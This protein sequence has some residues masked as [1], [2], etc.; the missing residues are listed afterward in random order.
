VRNIEKICLTIGMVGVCASVAGF[1]GLFY[2]PLSLILLWPLWRLAEILKHI[3][4]LIQKAKTKERILWMMLAIWWILHAVHVFVPETGFDAVW[5]H[6]P[7]AKLTVENHR[8]IADPTFYQTFNPLFADSIFFLGYMAGGDLGAKGVAYGFGLLLI[9]VTY[10][11]A[12]SYLP[13][14]E[15]LGVCVLVSGFQVVSW[16]ASSFYID[17]AKAVFELAALAF[18]L[19]KKYLFA[20]L[21]LGASLASKLFS[22]VLIPVY[23]WIAKRWSMMWSIVLLLPFLGMAYSATGNPV[24]SLSM[25]GERLLTPNYLMNQTLRLPLLPIELALSRDYTNLILLSFIPLLWLYR[26]QIQPLSPLLFLGGAQLFVWWYLPPQS[27]RYAVSG[28]ICLTIATVWLLKRFLSPRKLFV[29]FLLCGSI[30]MPI[31]GAVAWRSAQY[32]FGSQTRDAY[33]QQFL[34]GNIDIPLLKWHGFRR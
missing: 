21:M 25:H 30:A 34:D 13:R 9:A 32:L 11:L 27:T 4:F 23:S 31:R 7:V 17:L 29:C 16:Q 12:R 20:S 1:L 3:F 14:L 28:F 15:S 5:Y 10:W 2:P 8:F 22:L 26:K 24:F 6:L 33:L 19:E 18:L